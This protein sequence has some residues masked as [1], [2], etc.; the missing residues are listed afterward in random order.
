MSFKYLGYIACIYIYTYICVTI[1]IIKQRLHLWVKIL[2]LE[3]T[4]VC[5]HILVIEVMVSF[6]LSSLKYSAGHNLV[7]LMCNEM[8]FTLY[9][10]DVYI[11]VRNIEV[12][13]WAVFLVI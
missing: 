5:V 13:I 8:V 10:I 9:F 6:T 3:Y 11:N 12:V 1:K 2:K 4:V 7:Y